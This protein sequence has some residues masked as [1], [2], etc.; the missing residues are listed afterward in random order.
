MSLKRRGKRPRNDTEYI[1]KQIQV[2]LLKQ[3]LLN[4]KNCILDIFT[5]LRTDTAHLY[6]FLRLCIS[7]WSSPRRSNRKEFVNTLLNCI[8]IRCDKTTSVNLIHYIH[9]LTTSFN[10]LICTMSCR[11]SRS[12][13]SFLEDKNVSPQCA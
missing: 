4:T 5:I 13:F 9:L 2:S 8:T 3:H 11:F 12:A 1:I 6:R 10:C 7:T